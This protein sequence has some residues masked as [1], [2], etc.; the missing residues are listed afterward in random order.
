MDG[1][2][3]SESEYG[4]QTDKNPTFALLGAT[5]DGRRG[6]EGILN[7]NSNGG[8][9]PENGQNGERDLTSRVRVGEEEE[10][11]GAEAEDARGKHQHNGHND[12]N[13]N[14]RDQKSP[15][16]PDAESIRSVGGSKPQY[17]PMSEKG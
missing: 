15:P 4:S 6:G 12:N 7:G 17:P 8:E 14:D 11:E 5:M 16:A 3:R 13:N 9:V 1:L 2:G 10:E